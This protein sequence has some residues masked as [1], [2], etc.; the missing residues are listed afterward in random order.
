LNGGFFPVG[1]VIDAKRREKV[2]GR[3]RRVDWGVQLIMSLPSL[4]LAFMLERVLRWYA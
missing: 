3:G 1:C 4:P 2:R